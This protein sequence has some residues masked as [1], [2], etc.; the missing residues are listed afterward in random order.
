MFEA[1][2]R[3]HQVIR[4]IDDAVDDEADGNTGV[5][6]KNRGGLFDDLH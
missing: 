2:L 5:F 6:R 1:A 3:Q 4:Y